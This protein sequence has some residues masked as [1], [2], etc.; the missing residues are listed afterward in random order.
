MA[1]SSTSLA[2][3]EATVLARASARVWLGMRGGLVFAW[4]GQA[5]A[6]SLLLLLLA[7]PSVPTGQT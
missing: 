5:D 4:G 2:W 6:V 1:E 7:R 3:L